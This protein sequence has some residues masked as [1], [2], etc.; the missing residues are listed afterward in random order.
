MTD[1]LAYAITVPHDRLAAFAARLARDLEPDCAFTVEAL[2]AAAHSG[3]SW[4]LTLRLW[5]DAALAAFQREHV[6]IRCTVPGQVAVGYLYASARALPLG[7]EIHLWTHSRDIVA[8]L[9][10]SEQVRALLLQLGGY[11]CPPEVRITD[12]WNEVTV[13]SA[14]A[15]PSFGAD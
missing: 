4:A 12:E 5:P 11:G 15:E 13:L 2:L 14:A 8:A 1:S 10:H 3:E 9:K 7:L 6:D